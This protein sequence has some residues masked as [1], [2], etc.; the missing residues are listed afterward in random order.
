VI[1]YAPVAFFHCQHCEVV[2]QQAGAGN[3]FH[4]EQVSS[5]LPE[6]LR[7]EYQKLSEWVRKMLDTYGARVAFRVIDAASIEGWLKSL[8]YGIHEYPAVIVDHRQKIVG[9]DFDRASALI[10]ENVERF[11]PVA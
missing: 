5:S 2:W 1:A 6:D 10:R 7:Q 3:S 9:C 4:R 8:R 11:A